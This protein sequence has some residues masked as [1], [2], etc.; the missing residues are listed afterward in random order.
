M[1]LMGLF[2]R[3]ASAAALKDLRKRSIAG[4]T[5]SLAKLDDMAW[6]R[7]V[8]RL[9]E[10]R[11]LLPADTEAPEA[12][13]AHPLVR[14]W[15]GER[16]RTTNETAWR[17]GHSRLF[18]HLRQATHEGERPTLPQLASLYQAI[19]HGC[20]AGRHKAALEDVYL[21]RICRIDPGVGL[22]FYAEHTLGAF[23]SS[24]ASHSW[25]FDR[26]YDIPSPMLSPAAQAS[27]LGE[28]AFFMRAQ[29]RVSEALPLL[30]E[31]VA[32]FERENAPRAAALNAINVS[33]TELVLGQITDAIATARKSIVLADQP[34]PR[35]TTP[36]LRAPDLSAMVSARGALAQAL[37]AAGRLDDAT[38]WFAQAERL[39]LSRQRQSRWLSSLSEESVLRPPACERRSRRSPRA[40]NLGADHRRARGLRSR[41]WSRHPDARARGPTHC[42]ARTWRCGGSGRGARKGILRNNR[43]QTARGR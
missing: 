13:D 14:E 12:L 32:R 34:D 19:A 29:G 15:F 30:R 28:C 35:A 38:S 9:R 40:R 26:P 31:A 2:D 6:M 33:E 24:L 4:L 11:L 17:A 10:V 36:I 41:Y 21:R 8:A 37:H 16:L 20:Q 25:F 18:D 7:H 1:R 3:P 27:V 22:L 43:Q 39:L 42:V 23:S 5:D